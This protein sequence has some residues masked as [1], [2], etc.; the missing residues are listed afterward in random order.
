ME[1]TTNRYNFDSDTFDSIREYICEQNEN[2]SK[3]IV[4]YF[5]I[6]VLGNSIKSSACTASEET[7]FNITMLKN[8][9]EDPKVLKEIQVCN[10]LFPPTEPIERY[11]NSPK[12]LNIRK[13]SKVADDNITPCYVHNRLRTM[14]FDEIGRRIRPYTDEECNLMKKGLKVSTYNN[15]WNSF[16]KGEVGFTISGPLSC[17]TSFYYDQVQAYEYAHN[18]ERYQ[19]S[20]SDKMQ[21]LIRA[22]R[23][24]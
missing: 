19:E 11:L 8:P 4:D 23:I 24:L 17:I 2:F 9:N 3:E 6:V 12:A 14:I 20:I 1:K 13:I 21:P 16:S 5:I 15:T 22:K 18:G 10:Y 7:S